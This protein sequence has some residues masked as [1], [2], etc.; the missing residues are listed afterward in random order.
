VLAYAYASAL[1]FKQRKRLTLP[2]KYS[3]RQANLRA[4]NRQYFKEKSKMKLLSPLA[5]EIPIKLC[6]IGREGDI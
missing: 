2:L 4:A 6:F 1:L 3:D 5:G